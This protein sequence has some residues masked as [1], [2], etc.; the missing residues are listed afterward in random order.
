MNK[1]G[2]ALAKVIQYC[3]VEN[4]TWISVLFSIEFSWKLGAMSIPNPSF[5]LENT[6]A[7]KALAYNNNSVSELM[8]LSRLLRKHLHSEDACK[9]CF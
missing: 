3:T 7:Q 2:D 9:F 8:R 6:V 5:S 4:R 1:H